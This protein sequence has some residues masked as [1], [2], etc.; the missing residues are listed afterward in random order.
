[1]T[2]STKVIKIEEYLSVLS[3]NFIFYPPRNLFYSQKHFPATLQQAF[4]TI[5]K[6]Y[7]RANYHTLS[8]CNC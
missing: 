7:Y 6:I 1:M 4:R 8:T 3:Q 2:Y 5:L